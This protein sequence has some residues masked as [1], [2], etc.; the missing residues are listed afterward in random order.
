MAAVSAMLLLT[1]G[2]SGAPQRASVRLCAALVDGPIAPGSVLVSQPEQFDAFFHEAVLLLLEHSSD[3][4]S[5]GVLLNR[6]TPFTMGE[7]A[8]G[9]DCFADNIVYRGG[10]GGEDTVLMLHCQAGLPGSTLVGE[11]GLFLGGL[12]GAQELVG[13]GQVD[14][15]AFKFFFNTQVWAPGQL[16]TELE[17]NVW[18]ATDT[19]GATEVVAARGDRSLH[20]KFKRRLK[21]PA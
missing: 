12:K 6:E 11:S 17:S 16:Q 4:G 15:S 21:L 9:M 10:N 1:P 3:R 5:R 14:A 18:W 2:L 20:G 7:M 19:I 8:A 13:S